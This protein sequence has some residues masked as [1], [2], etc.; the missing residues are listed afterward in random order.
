M[1]R[2]P[3]EYDCRTCKNLTFLIQY[4]NILQE[5]RDKMKE[6]PK[7]LSTKDNIIKAFWNL[8]ESKPYNK[9]TVNDIAT[10]AGINRNTFYYH[11]QDIPDLFEK[12]IEYWVNETME[13]A[14]RIGA[15]TTVELV[16][17]IVKKCRESKSAIYNTYNSVHREALQEHLNRL[18]RTICDQYVDVSFSDVPAEPEDLRILK[19]YNKCMIIGIIYD[20]L[21]DGMEYDLVEDVKRITEL[22]YSSIEDTMRSHALQRSSA[23]IGTGGNEAK[24]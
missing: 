8:L 12:T 14:I 17:L 20:W 6:N 1:R 2:S 10:Q 3:G 18:V 11:F 5:V 15:S 21:D 22:F 24:R 9:I 16:A 4:D 23:P 19:K 7:E 13:E